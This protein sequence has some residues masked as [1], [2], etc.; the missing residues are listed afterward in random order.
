M[1]DSEDSARLE[2]LFRDALAAPPARG[3]AT[4]TAASKVAKQDSRTRS[5]DA[6]EAIASV[7]TARTAEGRRCHACGTIQPIK[8]ITCPTCYKRE[9]QPVI[10]KGGK[11]LVHRMAMIGLA[12]CGKT[13]YLAQLFAHLQDDVNLNPAVPWSVNLETVGARRFVETSRTL[14]RRGEWPLKTADLTR[15]EI[16]A[17]VKDKGGGRT[18]QILISD[19]SGDTVQ[20]FFSQND[21]A[22]ASPDEAK[23]LAH[24]FN[25]Q[26]ILLL[27]D[28]NRLTQRDAWDIEGFLAMYEREHGI[29]DE[30]KDVWLSI[31][32]TK[33]DELDRPDA[34]PEEVAREC[35]RGTFARLQECFHW[36]RVFLVSAAGKTLIGPD[37][38][39]MPDPFATPV[40]LHEPLAWVL[41]GIQAYD[42]VRRAERVERQHGADDEQAARLWLEQETLRRG[43]VRR[44]L[45]GLGV[46]LAAGLTALATLWAFWR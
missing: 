7:P 6:D 4:A 12:G 34:S 21:R 22:I 40:G 25:A 13:V 14:I 28:G 39:R 15:Q 38:R 43:R 8:R 36:V 37:G 26:S 10:S 27:I 24:V 3:G 5:D 30:A 23:Y 42:A 32:I 33:A 17:A 35:L 11:S 2:R 1:S 29:T 45:V 46:A 44:R 19:V 9:F 41:E 16:H 20:R 31:V 18:I